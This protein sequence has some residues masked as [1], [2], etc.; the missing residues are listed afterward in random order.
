MLL[1]YLSAWLGGGL[2][3]SI[4]VK[5]HHDHSNSYKGKHLIGAGLYI[6]GRL[7]HCCHGGK[8]RGMQAGMVLRKGTRVLNLG[9]QA[10]ER[11]SNTGP[12]LS[13]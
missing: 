4:V 9:P 13:F 7:I 10:S 3:V 8:H 6:L 5:R 2:R 11:E 1:H 12:G